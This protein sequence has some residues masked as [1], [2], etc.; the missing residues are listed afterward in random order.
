[1]TLALFKDGRVRIEL[2]GAPGGSQTQREGSISQE[3]AQRMG[4][5]LAEAKICDL[6]SSRDGVP[7]EVLP[8]LDVQF[9]TANCKVTLWDGEWN[10]QPAV[11]AVLAELR[12]AAK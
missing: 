10:E 5:S 7:D 1:M 12:A 8:T 9:A 2:G 4:A 3:R 6:S 11:Q